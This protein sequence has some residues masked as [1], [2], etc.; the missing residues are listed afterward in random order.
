[1]KIAYKLSCVVKLY[2]IINDPGSI[3]NILQKS[4]YT[5]RQSLIHYILI[6]CLI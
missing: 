2:R 4:V 3:S 6:V 1:M 5:T